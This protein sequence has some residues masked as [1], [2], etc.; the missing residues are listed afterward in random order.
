MKYISL[1]FEVLSKK[2]HF[3]FVG[4]GMDF[5]PGQAFYLVFFYYILF[6]GACVENAVI[7]ICRLSLPSWWLIFPY[8]Q[9]LAFDNTFYFSYKVLLKK[10]Q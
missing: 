9:L 3:L 1:S 8:L 10:L 7:R 6:A 2:I 4:L 5:F